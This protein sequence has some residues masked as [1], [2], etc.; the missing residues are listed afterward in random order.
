MR[1]RS[2][3]AAVSC[4]LVVI[5]VAWAVETQPRPWRQ[6]QGREYGDFPLP[7]DYAEKTEWVFAR[8]MYPSGNRRGFGRRGGFG[9]FRGGGDWREGGGSWT[10][11]YPRADRHL[12]PALRRLTRVHVRSVEQ[13]V[14]LDD[15][16]DVFNYPWLYA[17]EVGQ[18]DLTESQA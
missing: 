4:L 13:P 6:Y 10:T 2:V 18:W 17:V 7:P 14:N 1:L 15:E 3:V 11:D 12:A 8:L 9:G 16:D 5:G